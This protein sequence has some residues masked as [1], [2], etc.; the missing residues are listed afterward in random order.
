MLDKNVA[1]T[2]GAAMSDF[3]YPGQVTDETGRETL[4]SFI[5]RIKANTLQ[6]KF[7]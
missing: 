5:D 1:R 4:E 3:T 2:P 6:K 7:W